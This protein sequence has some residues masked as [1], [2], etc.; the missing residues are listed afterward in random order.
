MRKE[1][2]IKGS[3]YQHFKGSIMEV[4][5]IAKHSETLEDM[6]IYKH[7]NELWTRPISSFL[8]DEDISKRIDN[9]TGQTYRFERIR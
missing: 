5:D 1:E 9:V 3:F 4:V 2:V 6:V 7:D 8:S